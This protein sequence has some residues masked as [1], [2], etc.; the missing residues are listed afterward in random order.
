MLSQEIPGWLWG[1]PATAQL[2]HVDS[3]AALR[4]PHRVVTLTHRHNWFCV[5]HKNSPHTAVCAA[6]SNIDSDISLAGS[7]QTTPS[8]FHI[9]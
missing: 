6:P 1:V 5:A 4:P 7:T 3:T 9:Q 8:T 2:R